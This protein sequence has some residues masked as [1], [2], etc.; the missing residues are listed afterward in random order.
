MNTTQ[1]NILPTLE[2]FSIQGGVHVQGGS[3][4]NSTFNPFQSSTQPS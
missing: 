2:E 1:N 3:A 4:T